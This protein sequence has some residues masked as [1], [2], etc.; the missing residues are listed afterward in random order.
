MPGS[1]HILELGQRRDQYDNPIREYQVTY[2]LEGDS[3]SRTI[4]GDD[5]LEEF[6]S[7]HVGLASDAIRQAISELKQN[8]H[9]TVAEVEIPTEQAVASGMIQAPTET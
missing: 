8:R 3:F 7:G 1:L 5:K 6:L 4:S 2:A 9:A